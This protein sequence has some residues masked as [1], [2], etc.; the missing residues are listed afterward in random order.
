MFWI[1]LAAAV[2]VA[3]VFI[4]A[5][6]LLR[7]FV[8][9]REAGFD[10][11][12]EILRR[13]DSEFIESRITWAYRQEYEPL[14]ITSFD[15][16]KLRGRLLRGGEGP[17]VLCLH[18]YTSS[19]MMEFSPF[20]RFYHEAGYNI[21][22]PDM[23][24]HGESEGKYIGFGVLDRH[25][26]AA[27]CR[28]AV[29][30]FASSD[31]LIHGVSMGCATALMSTGLELPANVKGI[32]ADCGYTCPMSQFKHTISMAYHFPHF[33]VL[34]AASLLCKLIAHWSFGE[35]DTLTLMPLCKL[36]VLFIHGTADDFVLVENTYKNYHACAAQCAE[37]QLF[38]VKNAKHA[39][40]YYDDPY[41]YEE[42][43]LRFVSAGVRGEIVH[44]DS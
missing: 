7:V 28:E 1:C 32:I 26:C 38:L 37:K 42:A 3:A 18:G 33:P 24:A 17:V 13:T 27:W 12:Q 34:H 36:P 22:I 8:F 9:R 10:T 44:I 14:E 5:Y 29:R 41:G 20:I 11:L 39:R 23:R 30:L 15:G 4:A 19:G 25:D 31:I 16:L 35:V 21:M 40:S 2:V 43:V 6:I